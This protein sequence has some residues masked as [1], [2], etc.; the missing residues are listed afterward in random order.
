MTPSDEWDVAA[1]MEGAEED[2]AAD[3][4]LM[5]N[6]EQGLD[7][8]RFCESLFELVCTAC[9]AAAL[10]LNWQV[11]IWCLTVNPNEYLHVCDQVKRCELE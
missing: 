3:S 5:P 10:D 1:A 6:G 11:D 7:R 4:T 2:W 9:S 8:E